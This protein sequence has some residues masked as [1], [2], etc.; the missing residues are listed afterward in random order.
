MDIQNIFS[1]AYHS[2]T[3]CLNSLNIFSSTSQSLLDIDISV[4][5][6]S[7]KQLLHCHDGTVTVRNNNFF[8]RL[9]YWIKP[10]EETKKTLEFL[11]KKLVDTPTLQKDF[12]LKLIGLLCTIYK[13]YSS[14]VK[15]D[16]SDKFKKMISELLNRNFYKKVNTISEYS[17]EL[18]SLTS[19]LIEPHILSTF[20]DNNRLINIGLM[21]KEDIFRNTFLNK[22]H[23]NILYLV[24]NSAWTAIFRILKDDDLRL[25]LD[26]N[27]LN[28]IVKEA[29]DQGKWRF[30]DKINILQHDDL[31]LKLSE[32]TM[33]TLVEFAIDQGKWD[34]IVDILKMFEFE[35]Q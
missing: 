19:E 11:S 24:K 12:Q 18:Q 14:Q 26:K 35:N 2:I 28:I 8:N 30:I 32:Q 13:V 25:K 16:C 33:H 17:V 4:L 27:D 6:D 31:R 5:T 3:T 29:I 22:F 34:L 20:S 15:T 21:L 7:S 9:I 23:E 10:E 1:S